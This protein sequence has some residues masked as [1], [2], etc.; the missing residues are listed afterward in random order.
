MLSTVEWTTLIAWCRRNWELPC[1]AQDV[2]LSDR[3]VPP[4]PEICVYGISLAGW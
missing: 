1:A 3:A 2:G 4:G